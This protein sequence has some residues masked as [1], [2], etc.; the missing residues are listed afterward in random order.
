MELRFC[1]SWVAALPYASCGAGSEYV[2]VQGAVNASNSGDVILLQAAEYV[3]NVA[4]ANKSLT[5]LGPNAGVTANGPRSLEATIQGYVAVSGTSSVSFDGLRFLAS[6]TT[7]GSPDGVNSLVGF[8]G[9]S[10]HSVRNSIFFSQVNGGSTSPNLRAVMFN[11]AVSGTISVE[12]N[13]FTG[14]S[15][16][17]FGTAAWHRGVWSDVGNI[18]ITGNTFT[19]TRTAINLENSTNS[20]ITSNLFSLAGTGISL[21]NNAPFTFQSNQFNDVDTDINGQNVAAVI[22]SIWAQD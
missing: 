22:R 15:L 18:A 12:N 19:S 2:S 20:S 14:T 5:F 8:S 7:T 16:G 21:S 4:I 1:D 17:K 9:G 3:E 10:A 13:L 11:T 6:S